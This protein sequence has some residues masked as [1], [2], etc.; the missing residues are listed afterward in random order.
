MSAPDI[1]ALVALSTTNPNE[2]AA[3]RAAIPE[4]P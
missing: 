3:L 1:G 2:A 4:A